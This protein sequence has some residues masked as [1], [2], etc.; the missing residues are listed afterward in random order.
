MI[1][2]LLIQ[3]FLCSCLLAQEID[4]PFAQSL[5]DSLS[6]PG[7]DTL[8]VSTTKKSKKYDLDDI[9]FTKAQDSV[10]FDI[11]QKKMYI[12]GSGELKYKNTDLKGG[13]IRID[14]Q[15]NELEAEGI[16]DTKDSVSQSVIQTPVLT[17]AGDS[18]EGSKLKYNFKT[19][20][21]FISLAKNKKESSTYRGE[22]VKKVDKNTFFI[23]DG[24]YTTCDADTPHTYFSASEMKVIQGDKIIAKWIFM[25]IGGV[26]LP[27]PIPFGVFP[28]QTGRQSGIIIP[29]YGQTATRGAYFRNFGY[30][31]ALSDYMD[32]ALTG[33]YYMK[34][35]YGA[36]GRYRYA[37][38]YEFNGNVSGGFS[39]LT[40]G[41]T[42][43]PGRTEQKDWNISVFHNQQFNPTTRLDVNLQFQTSSY[44]T[45]NSVTYDEL[46]QKDIISN[47]TL[48]KRW[49]ESGNSMTLNYNRTQNLE[50]GN[51]SEIL[52]SLS[53]YMPL[54]YP[55]KNTLSSGSDQEWYEYIGYSYTGQFK[56]TRNKTDGDLKIRGGLQHNLSISASPK[57]GYFSISPRITY[58]EKWYNKQINRDLFITEIPADSLN[59]DPTFTESLVEDDIHKIDFVRT[60]DFSLSASTK[61]YGMSQINMLGV[62]AF[63]HTLTPS[64][65]YNFRPD[66]SEDKWGYY[67]SYT[68][69]NGEVVRYDRFQREVYGGVSAGE[70]QSIN[71]SV[72]NLFEIKTAKD[73]TDTTSQ[74]EKLRLLNLTASVGYNFATDTLKLSD[75]N[76][77][78]RT[79]IGDILNFSGSSR[80]TFYD[81]DGSR[82]INEFLADKG[83][84]LLR[85]SNL[86]LSVSASISGDKIRGESRT[87][88]EQPA[89]DDEFKSFERS[90]YINL[91]DEE[92]ADFTIPWNLSL[93]VNYNLSK[94]TPSIV[95]KTAS[96]GMNLGFNLT[97]NWKF[98]VR[99]NYDLIR[100]EISA[101]Q[102]TIYRDLHCW[103]MNF[104]WKPM[105]T[106]RGFNLELRLKAPELQDIKV[107]KSEGLYSGLKIKLFSM[108]KIII[109]GNNLIGKIKKFDLPVEKGGPSSREKLVFV[110]ERYFL[111]KKIKISL[112]FDGF[113]KEVIKS[114]KIKIIYSENK[115]ADENI[116]DEIS[117]SKNPRLITLITSDFN[118]SQFGSVNS[119]SIIKSEIFAHNIQKKGK[120]D[121]EKNRINQIDISEIKKIFGVE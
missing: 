11:S 64:I 16:L 105:G 88:K 111:N 40:T 83:K 48:S 4:S 12:H 82:K 7:S 3:L 91:F 72:G 93:N 26:P 116:K 117:G 25:N 34:G 2:N 63:R 50:S 28:N 59:P 62:E 52:P 14:F 81:Y 99:G 60:F 74:A 80:Y 100:K 30:Y 35:G 78:Y 21:G 53:F 71:L 115:S 31:F 41:E 61:I 8:V 84:G 104:S 95:T 58:T 54:K 68:T 92:P 18:F 75:L 114:S 17:E 76:L 6:L 107:T 19:Q 94:P 43:D 110:L 67:D 57:L 13:T 106:Y 86:N 96:V 55:F 44:I 97:K 22:A 79:Q 46:L 85:L 112:H 101:P 118:L 121:S 98:T 89:D 90:D 109:D 103:E 39:N 47:A 5:N 23:K 56:N 102:V 77:S 15:T 27:I 108:K 9:V 24:I 65:S 45:N 113:E 120:N 69:A 87:G 70:R 51:I 38:R 73:P 20:R 36:R 10:L 32:L 66:F 37:K 49:D 119:C 1:K 42:G 33:D 29:T